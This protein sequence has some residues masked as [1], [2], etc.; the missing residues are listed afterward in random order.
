M[1]PMQAG[2]DM[3]WHLSLFLRV[4]TVFFPDM[5]LFNIVDDI[6]VGTHVAAGIFGQVAALGGGYVAI[7]VLVAYLFFAWREL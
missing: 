5:Q 1:D 4:I 7:Y 6:A 2:V 3:P